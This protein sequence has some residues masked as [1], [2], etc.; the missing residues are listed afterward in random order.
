MLLLYALTLFT[1]AT[2]LF[3]V[4]LIIGKMITPLLGGTPEVWNTCMVF[5]QALL[6][7]GYAYAHASTT[8]LGVRKQSYLH[9]VILLVPLLFFPIAVNKDLI[10]KI[11]SEHPIAAV[12]AVLFLSVGVP[13]FAVSTSAPLLQKWFSTTSH[14]AASDPYF[15]Y[16]ASNLG[17]MLAL[18]GYPVIVEPYLRLAD[19][20]LVWMVGYGA[21]VACIAGCAVCMWYSQ[22][23]EPS[24]EMG[25][26]DDKEPQT[27][28]TPAGPQA[29]TGQPAKGQGKKRGK[30]QVTT[31]PAPAP[32][33]APALRPSLTADV[34]WGRRLR[35][36]LLA[37][38]PSSLLLG[39]T[40]FITTDIAPIPLLWIPPLGLYLLTFILVF[41]KWWEDIGQAIGYYTVLPV[42]QLFGFPWDRSRVT[43]A[44]FHK[45]LILTMPL[46]LLLLI[47][48]MQSGVP[49]LRIGQN[50][51]FHLLT[52]FVVALVCHG[53]LA[54][55]RPSTKYLTEFFMWMSF[56]G[57]VGGMFNGLLAPVV[58]NGLWEYPLGMVV[59]CLLLP[60]L[61][62]DKE[63]APGW[64]LYADLALAGLFLVASGIL[65]WFRVR[66]HNLQFELLN[67]G[68]LLWPVGVLVSCAVIAAV[69]AYRKPGER[70]SRLLDF[71]LPLLLGLLVVGLSWGLASRMLGPRVKEAAE[72][73]SW[74]RDYFRQALVFGLPCVLCYTFVERSIRFGLGVGAILLASGFL[75]LMD[76]DFYYQE[77]GFFGVLRVEVDRDDEDD[78]Q[79]ARL[80]H[81]TTLHGKQFTEYYNRRYGRTPLTY[82]HKTGPVGQVCLAYNRE[83]VGVG[84][85]AGTYAG[86]YA[87][88]D[89][90]P[91]MAVVGLGTG[92]MSCYA[93]PG[94]K[95]DFYDID[96]L[97]AKL[98]YA[99]PSPARLALEKQ[100]DDLV[101]EIRDL[102]REI[103]QL[104][105][106]TDD[107]AKRTLEVKQTMLKSKREEYIRKKATLEGMPPYFTYVEDARKRG[108]NVK[109]HL[110][111]ARLAIEQKAKEL[112]PLNKSPEEEAK[113]YGIM[114]VDAFSSDAIPI[115]LI[116]LEAL[117]LYLQVLR[118]DGIL[119]FHISNRY[120]DLR[121]VLANLVQ[122]M[123]DQ[124]TPLSGLYNSDDDETQ[125]GKA[126][127]TWVMIARKP[128]YMSRLLTAEQW[129]PMR[130]ELL[131]SLLPVS[132]L[133]ISDLGQSCQALCFAAYGLL[134][135]KYRNDEYMFEAPW[136]PLSAHHKPNV[137]VWT[138]DYAPILRVFLW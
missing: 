36:I 129:E 89:T 13:F 9:L 12:L 68:F 117:K 35:W 87:W 80:V 96:P 134:D 74:K 15:L 10:L 66:D 18:F 138:D 81:G 31:Q 25:K 116:T 93:R 45:V 130:K 19:Q 82:Y 1:S 69:Y 24:G 22:P 49:N 29:V 23:T 30:E 46:I 132:C 62:D 3:L 34:T 137:G 133:P 27:G 124:G 98:S 70:L 4:Q 58:F 115:H 125:P 121:P 83:P 52:L 105:G 123:T 41:S 95:L 108:V 103:Q 72:Y 21:L 40:T 14:P 79:F 60:P 77:R 50:V 131:A 42:A 102:Q 33:P 120:L 122:E 106:A 32:A 61:M 54:R 76:P 55:D 111:D 88:K 85:L 97:V 57:V 113:R 75:G 59:A 5:F 37:A 51:A 100:L 64:G 8:W 38:V 91:N 110:A 118:E 44:L 11:G 119:C 63:E 28:I 107:E 7:A 136:K 104:K 43:A 86:T 39:T 109:L 94:Q 65:I 92:T 20:R 112:D 17:S 47:F 16:G 73:I 101:D 78:A 48:V 6:L 67:R 2:L 84:L 26:K 135:R 99:E 90:A 53:E 114:V 127:S 56:G 126:R 71:V 128:E